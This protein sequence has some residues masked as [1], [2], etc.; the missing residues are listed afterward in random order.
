MTTRPWRAGARYMTWMIAAVATMM[1]VGCRGI[2][3]AE[4]PDRTGRQQRNADVVRDAFAR[5]VGD[6]I[7]RAHV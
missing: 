3:N 2:G 6:Q 4:K 1:A 5:G 7:G